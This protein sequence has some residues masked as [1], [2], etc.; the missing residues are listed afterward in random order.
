MLATLFLIPGPQHDECA[1]L[2]SKARSRHTFPILGSY[3]LPAT[4]T[5]TVLSILPVLTT[6]PTISLCAGFLNATLLSRP[7]SFAG[8][9]CCSN[10]GLIPCGRILFTKRSVVVSGKSRCEAL[11]AALYPLAGVGAAWACN[12][13]AGESVGACAPICT[14]VASCAWVWVV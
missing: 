3:L 10:C 4:L 6:T 1:A 11:R 9:T 7:C 8:S 2:H 5:L 14:G 13:S 12:G